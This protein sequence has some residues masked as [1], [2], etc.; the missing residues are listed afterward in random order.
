MNSIK[1]LLGA[2]IIF[3][4][5]SI[6]SGQSVSVEFSYDTVFLGNVVQL[7]YSMENFQ[8]ELESPD[9]GDFVVVSGP[10]VSTSVSISGGQRFSRKSVSFFLKPPDIE[11]TYTIPSQVFADGEEVITSVEKVI[12]VAENPDNIKQNPQIETKRSSPFIHQPPSREQP[13]QR[14]KRRKF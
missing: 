9:F 11:G 12:F 14:G 4:N 7:K 13:P 2:F 3:T 10:N 5:L 6:L 8:G 1:I